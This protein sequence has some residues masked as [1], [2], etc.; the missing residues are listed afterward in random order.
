MIFNKTSK[1]EKQRLKED[2][3]ASD[4]KTKELEEQIQS[5]EEELQSDQGTLSKDLT[6][7]EPEEE[8]QGAFQKFRQG[9]K[10]TSKKIMNEL[11][12][13]PG[14][15]EID[16]DFLENLEERLLAADMGVKTTQRVMDVIDQ[17]MRDRDITTTAEVI[18]VVKQVIKGVLDKKSS[19]P[20]QSDGGPLVYL[21]VGVNGVGKTTSI[22]KIAAQFKAEGKKVLVAAGDTFRAAAIDQLV[23]WC[24]RSDVDCVAKG[25]NSDPSATMYEAAER[26][27]NENYDILLC[28]TSGRLHTKK[29]LMDELLKMDRVLKKVIPQAPH[30]SYLVLDANTG[31]NAI[32]QTKEF[33]ELINLDG[34]IITKLDGT[35]KGGVVIGIVNEFDIP[36]RYI[37]VGEAID[38]LRS[39]SA[40]MFTESLFD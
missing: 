36:I 12:L 32:N 40:S 13:I 22:G 29:N 1:E 11:G 23:E 18:E 39:F 3:I 9:L 8:N 30:Q 4:L 15:Q 28:D 10:K 38:D 33:S 7:V 24:R 26:A 34:L 35:A 6:L 27:K 16:D 21:F 17:K 25:E 19:D 2:R 20:I 31:Q 14:A 5:K 37:G